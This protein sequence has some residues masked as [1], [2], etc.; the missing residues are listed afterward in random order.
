M[1]MSSLK[2]LLT[3][4][5]LAVALC[6][7]LAAQ[8]AAASAPYRNW[9]GPEYAWPAS[10]LPAL[11]LSGRWERE[12][13]QSLLRYVAEGN[14][15][16]ITLN[17]LSPFRPV[18][19]ESSPLWK[20]SALILE[21]S[22]SAGAYLFITVFKEGDFLPDNGTDSLMGYAKALLKDAERTGSSIEIVDAPARMGGRRSLLLGQNAMGLGWKYY[23]AASKRHLVRSDYF[24]NQP[25]LLLVVSMTAPEE[26]HQGLRMAA[27]EL[28]RNAVP[29]TME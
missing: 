22:R 20:G 15:I 3:F 1:S 29:V 7:Q 25:G 12:E 2:T 8:Q 19:A 18:S 13:S 23:D 6:Q 4:A 24:F 26:S 27:E 21:D 5:I 10:S 17:T 28:L 11:K 14:G 16:R 9:T